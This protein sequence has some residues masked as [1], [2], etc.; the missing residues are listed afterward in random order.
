MAS[1]LD[2]LPCDRVAEA[3]VERGL[4]VLDRGAGG[5]RRLGPLVDTRDAEA[6][7]LLSLLLALLPREVSIVVSLLMI[8]PLM[9]GNN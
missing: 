3:L 8:E 4:L 1:F 9:I 6:R 5:L 7:E 2:S